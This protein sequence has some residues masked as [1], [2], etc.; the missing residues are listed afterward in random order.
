MSEL[1]DIQSH[2]VAL[3]P[4]Y[5]HRDVLSDHDGLADTTRKDQHIAHLLWRARE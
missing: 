3:D 5:G 1:I 2:L 4:K